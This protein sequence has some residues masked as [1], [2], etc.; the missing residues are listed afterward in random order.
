MSS[1]KDIIKNP[2]LTAK[3]KP[4]L[5]SFLGIPP[6]SGQTEAVKHILDRYINKVKP[7]FVSIHGRVG[8]KVTKAEGIEY[9]ELLATGFKSVRNLYIGEVTEES[10]SAFGIL[11]AFRQGLIE[12]KKLPLFD[13]SVSRLSQVFENQQLNEHLIHTYRYLCEQESI[14]KQDM[15]SLEDMEKLSKKDQEYATKLEQLL[16]EGIA[17]VIMWD[18][19]LNKTVLHFLT[20]L[21]GHLY[22]CH[23]WLFLDLQR[24]LD[25]LHLPPTSSNGDEREI[26]DGALLMKWRPR[27]HYLIRSCRLGETKEKKRR[28]VCTVFAKHDGT[29]NGKMQ[30][31]MDELE[32][33]VQATARHIDVTSLLKEKIVPVNLCSA[34]GQMD[35]DCLLRLNQ[36]LQHVI[37][38][39][40]Y[41]DI[42]IAWIF[43]RSLFYRN[44]KCVITKNELERMAKECGMDKSSFAGFCKFYTSFGSIFDLS[45]VDEKCQTVAVKPM[46]FLQLLDCLLYPSAELRKK[47]PI[48][49]YGIYPEEICREVFDAADWSLF[50]D[51]LISLSL[52]IKVSAHFIEAPTDI[53][54][55]RNATYY[56]IPLSRTGQFNDV[57]HPHS[58]HIITSINTPH[59]FRQVAVTKRLLGILEAPK[60]IPSKYFNQTTI[61]DASTGTTITIVSHSPATRLDLDKP[62]SEVCGCIVRVYN[63]I[64]ETCNVTVKYKFVRLCAAEKISDVRSIPSSS[65]HILPDN[66]LCAICKKPENDDSD[67][68]QAWNK[69]LIEVMLSILMRLLLSYFRI[70]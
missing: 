38:E 26:R 49:S 1:L 16:P 47:Y 15:K 42:P 25:K 24:D 46:A 53:P 3:V 5:I 43:L 18:V 31:K 59:V 70:K 13:I 45:L 14:P 50:M 40:S 67:L 6:A 22:N 20:A 41:E 56:F 2:N 33:K 9:H 54:L 35:D 51:A 69:A 34:A 19:A 39:A 28:R 36:E 52:A 11:S 44:E 64:A 23:P 58:I 57:P 30:E 55:D 21:R 48:I 32:R 8:E 27:L 61:K 62:N 7:P 29:F 65:Y 12:E 4:A 60:L 68:L 10:T 17:L 37:C 66:E 63:E